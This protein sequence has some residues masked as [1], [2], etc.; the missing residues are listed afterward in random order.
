VAAGAIAND[1]YVALI[2]AVAL[3]I[4]VS[5]VV[6]RMAASGRGP[7]PVAGAISA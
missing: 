6:V 4:G 3:S 2:A 1:T 7:D 5:T